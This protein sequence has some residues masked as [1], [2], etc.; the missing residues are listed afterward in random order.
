MNAQ[1]KQNIKDFIK[2]CDKMDWDN[3]SNLIIFLENSILLLKE[4][5]KED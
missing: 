1:T 2:S 4:S 3:V 5:I